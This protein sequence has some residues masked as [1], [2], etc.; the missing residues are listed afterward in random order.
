MTHTLHARSGRFED[1]ADL[2]TALAALSPPPDF[3]LL[4]PRI[5]LGANGAR[6]RIGG[7]CAL[8]RSLP[9]FASVAVGELLLSWPDA[10]LRLVVDG[11]TRC[12]AALATDAALMPLADRGDELP[13]LSELE[14]RLATVRFRTD[15]DLAR[16]QSARD[17]SGPV[18]IEE[19]KI[20]V[21][22][23]EA[24]GRVVAWWLV[25]EHRGGQAHGS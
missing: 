1:D 16:F 23:F 9:D 2:R 20:R 22:S 24:A 13:V 8:T 6:G 10:A 15:R 12:W 11:E 14:D 4:E 3:V 5:E 17:Q 25:E 21:R 19:G 18:R 7:F